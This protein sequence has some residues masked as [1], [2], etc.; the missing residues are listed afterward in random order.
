MIDIQYIV[1]ADKNYDCGLFTPENG[2]LTTL[3][4]AIDSLED[5]SELCDLR[6]TKI[7]ATA[8]GDL[9]AAD[10]TLDALEA[11]IAAYEFDLDDDGMGMRLGSYPK[12]FDAHPD[13]EA[14]EKA[15]ELSREHR[16]EVNHIKAERMAIHD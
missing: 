6:V 9:A 10:V 3:Q 8:S 2:V 14:S 13:F 7:E 11:L 15:Q 12:I 1:Q 16:D 4:E 5:V